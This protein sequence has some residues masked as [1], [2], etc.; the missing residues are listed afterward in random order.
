[1]VR[2]DRPGDGESSD[3]LARGGGGYVISDL[4]HFPFLSPNDRPSRK[5]VDLFGLESGGTKGSVP[6]T[7]RECTF[8]YFF[9]YCMRVNEREI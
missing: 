8:S 6:Q 5:E 9:V 7:R 2:V 3:T 4:S 1:M